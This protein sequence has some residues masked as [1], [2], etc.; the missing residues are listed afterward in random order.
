MPE[1]EFHKKFS[2]KFKELDRKER[3]RIYK[4][5]L[6][7]ENF[8]FISLDIKKLKGYMNTYRLRVG[9]HRIKF[10][11]KED[12]IV[13]YDIEPRGKAYRRK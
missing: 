2:R 12:K 5:L 3:E 9:G 7:L 1:L 11:L 10:V 13:F 8:P 6:L 4:R